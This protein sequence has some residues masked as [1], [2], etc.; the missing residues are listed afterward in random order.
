MQ[1]IIK[2]FFWAFILSTIVVAC[3]KEE[4]ESDLS[5]GDVLNFF[6][7]GNDKYS[8]SQAFLLESG[9]ETA[10]ST[11]LFALLLASEGLSIETSNLDVTGSGTLVMAVF[12]SPEPFLTSGEY[13]YDEM[14]SY[15]AYTYFNGIYSPELHFDSETGTSVEP[16]MFSSGKITVNKLRNGYEFTITNAVDDHS[17]PISGHYKGFVK[18]VNMLGAIR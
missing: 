11:C 10:D 6:Q 7:T 1:K 18:S 4:Y 17:M 8:L 13:L 15:A 3:D 16:R 5:D 2:V 9:Q 12:F 14:S